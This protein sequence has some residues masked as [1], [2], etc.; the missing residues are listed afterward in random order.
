MKISFIGA[1][2]V[3][4]AMATYMSND[5]DILYF[6]SRS[7]ASA[8]EAASILGCHVAGIDT[9]IDES[10]VIFV[11]TNDNAIQDVVNEIS[12]KH[13]KGKLFIHMS[14]ALSSEVFIPLKESGAYTC[15][16]HPL[17]TFTDTIKAVM[18][19]KKAYFSL[20]GDIEQVLPIVHKLGNPYFELSKEQKNKY[21]LSACVFSNYLVTLMNY[22]SRILE[23]IGIDEENGLKAMQPLIDATLSNIYLKGTK[24]ALTGPIQRG[25]TGTLEKHMDELEGLDLE[26]YQLLGRLTTDALIMDKNKQS[27]LDAI[28]RKS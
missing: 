21:H 8:Q 2:K 23:S 1:G 3:G 20:E 26:A 12:L 14:G 25:D 18:D 16:M 22:G 10:D 6:H 11:T 7:P 15:S 5:F 27:I 19:L 28:W 4:T 17:Q 9:L 13:L 24:N